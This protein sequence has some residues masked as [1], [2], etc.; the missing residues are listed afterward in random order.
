MFNLGREWDRRV[1][2]PAKDGRCPFAEEFTT[3]E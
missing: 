2:S 1:E 3:E